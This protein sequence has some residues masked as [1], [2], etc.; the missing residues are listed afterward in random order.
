MGLPFWIALALTATPAI[1]FDIHKLM[2]NKPPSPPPSDD[3]ASLCSS[4]INVDLQNSNLKSLQIHRA[5][6]AV[7]RYMVIQNVEIKKYYI[8]NCLTCKIQNKVLIVRLSFPTPVYEKKL[9]IQPQ[10]LPI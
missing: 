6:E 9:L 3:D 7:H 4:S 8:F 10:Q 2:G 1:F 5:T